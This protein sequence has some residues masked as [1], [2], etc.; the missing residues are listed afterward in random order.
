MQHT[1]RKNQHNLREISPSLLPLKYYK[2]T[3]YRKFCENPEMM[4]VF[5]KD[6][7]HWLNLF[8][9]IHPEDEKTAMIMS[10]S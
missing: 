9:K 1:L 5:T 8:K 10:M 4:P 2:Q 7:F 3:D 6:L